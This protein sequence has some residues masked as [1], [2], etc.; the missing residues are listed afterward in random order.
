MSHPDN[1]AL[2]SGKSSESLI[3]AV[4]TSSTVP[5]TG[6]CGDCD[7]ATRVSKAD[8]GND[9]VWK[10]WKA[11][12][13]AFHPSHTLWKSL[14]DYHI[15]TAST[16]GIFQGARARETEC[17]GLW[18]SRGLYERRGTATLGTV[19]AKDITV[20]QTM[21]RHAKPD[22]TAIYTHGNFGKALD[23]QRVF[24][25]QPLRMKPAS[26]STQ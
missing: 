16:A 4:R 24:M 2:T 5:N 10:G 13:P 1:L 21:L 22:T 23:A 19:A 20:S 26:E 15:P 11:K 12:N 25:K 17:K 14:R 6:L 9:R 18:T 8:H 3:E 7:C